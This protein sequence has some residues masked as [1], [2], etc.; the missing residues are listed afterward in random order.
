MPYKLGL[1]NSAVPAPSHMIKFVLAATV[2][3]SSMRIIISSAEFD[4][5]IDHLFLFLFKQESFKDAV[6]NGHI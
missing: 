3:I 2:G 5:Q 1:T 6:L 4:F